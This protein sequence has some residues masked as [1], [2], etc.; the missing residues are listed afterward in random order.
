MTDIED[1]A[2]DVDGEEGGLDGGEID[3]GI[4]SL[5]PSFSQA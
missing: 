3:R 1:A 4:I 5:S 2:C